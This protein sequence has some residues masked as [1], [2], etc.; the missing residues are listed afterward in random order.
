MNRYNFKDVE[1][2]WQT[3]WETNK[4]FKSKIIKN[5]KK[6]YC[7]EISLSQSIDNPSFLS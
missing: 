7:L 3:Y 2:K 5:K 6:F 1:K 4:T